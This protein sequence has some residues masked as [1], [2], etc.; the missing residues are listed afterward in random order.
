MNV[1]DVCGILGVSKSTAYQMI[2]SLN[3]EL[4]KQGYVTIHG[5]VSR[6]F[7]FEKFYGG[8]PEKETDWKWCM[9][10]EMVNMPAYKDK[11]TGKWFVKLIRTSSL[12]NIF[13]VL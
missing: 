7:F 2:R 11:V 6:K 13:V 3:E 10:K 5:K 8:D 12:Q 4:K 9:E 1:D